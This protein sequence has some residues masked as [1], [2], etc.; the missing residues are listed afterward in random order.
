MK[1]KYKYLSSTYKL[2]TYYS[3]KEFIN[4]SFGE[5]KWDKVKHLTP[6]EFMEEAMYIDGIGRKTYV[7]GSHTLHYNG[8]CDCSTQTTR[9]KCFWGRW[10]K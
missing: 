5:K 7:A 1:Y 8:L 4:Y 2:E 6:K 10:C 9:R 3:C